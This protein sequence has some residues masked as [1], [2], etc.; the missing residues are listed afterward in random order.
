V[1]A[2]FEGRAA[3]VFGG[4]RGIG[5]ATARRFAAEGASVLVCDILVGEG[6]ATA[7]ALPVWATP[8]AF[9]RVD[10]GD[11]AAVVAAVDEARVLFGRLDVLVSNV[12]IVRYG[13]P[14]ELSLED[15]DLTMAVNLRAQFA[16]ARAALPHMIEAGR[17]VIV[18]TAS[19]LAHGF[20]RN[21]V[22]YSTSKAAILGL[23]RAI[24][25]EYADCGI[26]CVSISPGAIDTPILRIAAQSF[27]PDVAATLASW[28]R[29][30]PVGRLGTA[31]EVAALVAFLASDEAGFIT[32]MDY[33]VDG[34]VRAGL[35]N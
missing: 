14:H 17:G 29:A 19:V 11:A 13:K 22:A 27:G 24:A 32:G 30:H 33:A 2:R 4:A 34:G 16:A 9:R 7:A 31:E 6:E 8:S 10:V 21:T 3:V 5:A 35:Y 18:N 26:R 23:T 1:S 28:G 12:G 15:W 25:V 20:Q